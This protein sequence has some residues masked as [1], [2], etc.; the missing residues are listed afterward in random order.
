MTFPYAADPEAW[1]D[2]Q[3]RMRRATTFESGHTLNA[4][5]MAGILL[6]VGPIPFVYGRRYRVVTSGGEP[7]VKHVHGRD[8]AGVIHGLDVVDIDWSIQTIEGTYRGR[9]TAGPW[10]PTRKGTPG[11]HQ[12]LLESGNFAAVSDMDVLRAEEIP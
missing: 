4:D 3:K 11:L 2:R 1:L 5:V 10:G 6:E 8:E 12:F 9:F 7:K